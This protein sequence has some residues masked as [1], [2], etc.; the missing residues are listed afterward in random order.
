[1]ALTGL[2]YINIKGGRV[3]SE[4]GATLEVGGKVGKSALSTT[5]FEGTFTDEIKPGKVSFS[6]IHTDKDD[7][8]TYQNL[9]DE[10]V[11][12]ETDSGQTYLINRAGTVGEVKLKGNTFDVEMEGDPAELL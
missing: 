5:G 11:T 10:P 4:K 6:V 3:R 7:L 2:S 1:M 9:R 12:F 8:T